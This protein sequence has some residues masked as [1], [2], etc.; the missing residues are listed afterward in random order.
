MVKGRSSNNIDRPLTIIDL[1]INTPLPTTE[2]HELELKVIE[3]VISNHCF[4][5]TKLIKTFNDISQKDSKYSNVVGNSQSTLRLLPQ[6]RN[7]ILEKVLA[8]SS[9]YDNGCDTIYFRN[10]K[11]MLVKDVRVVEDKLYYNNCGGS[12]SRIK[13]INV[14]TIK[15]VHLAN[16]N[17]LNPKKDYQELV[18]GNKR[19]PSE[20]GKSIG[21]VAVAIILGVFGLILIGLSILLLLAVSSGGGNIVSAFLAIV[22]GYAFGVILAIGALVLII[23]AFVIGFRKQ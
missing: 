1:D 4:K 2:S 22:F 14:N 17:V 15:S 20:K 7:R 5:K 16:G 10:G 18:K 13:P 9:L 3:P 19:K 11:T 12:N 23:M 6:N 21:R 8:N